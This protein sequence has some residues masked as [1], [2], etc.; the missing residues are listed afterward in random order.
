MNLR[1]TK[2][3]DTNRAMVVPLL[4]MFFVSMGANPP[5][6]AKK[7][8]RSEEP[9]E[10][11]L[12]KKNKPDSPE[13]VACTKE[14]S[15]L[16]AANKAVDAL[17]VLKLNQANCKNS[18]SFNLLMSTILLRMPT[19]EK[20]AAQAAAL[21]VSADPD[22]VPANFQL[23]IC[24]TAGG[25]AK[26]AV[27]AYEK[28]VS[29]DPTNYEAWS[30]LGTLYEQLH[31]K[32]KAKSCAEKAADLEP[33][34]R[35]AKIRSAQNLFKQGKDASVA[36]ELDRLLSDEHLEPEFF[37]GLAKD[38]LEMQAYAES[39]RAADKALSAY[40]KFAD[41]LK[42]KATAQLWKRQYADGL[43]TISK[44]DSRNTAT[45]VS[46]VKAALLL[47]L[48]KTKEAQIYTAKIPANT[49]DEIAALAKG[50]IAQR[51]GE[52]SDAIALFENAMRKN[53]LFAP[54]HIELARIYLRQGRSEELIAEAREIARSRPFASTAK[55][56]ESRLALEEAPRREKM[57]LA[58]KLAREAVKLNGDDPEALTALALSELKGGKIDSARESI[59]KALE[60]EPG[61]I[62]VLLANAKLYEGDGNADKRIE[63]LE[64]IEA[65]APGDSEVLI[66]LSQA[67]CDKGDIAGAIKMLRGKISE[68]KTDAVVYFALARACD[69][70]GKSKDA[71]KYYKQSLSTGL[72]GQRASLAREALKNIGSQPA[73]EN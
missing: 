2:L 42:T 35:T 60:I 40:P 53:Q 69:R 30:G 71:A 49:T 23:A 25:D 59:K 14:A 56:F 41:L 8:Q 19:H 7:S 6:E 15:K 47:K 4:A 33:N 18:L 28:V 5:A 48:G 73:D 38:A 68:A 50:F 24:A 9:P 58:V 70:N 64:A 66:A 57:E 52:T 16:F 11:T 44:I 34:S 63:T 22:S 1:R 54:A 32:T 13:C 27:T 61:N 62:D 55:S 37:I 45:D 36:T 43:A 20:E 10:L 21:A 39:I 12:T 17:K 65:I 51:N 72:T 67:Y 31:D 29:I 46:A 26:Q 3:Q